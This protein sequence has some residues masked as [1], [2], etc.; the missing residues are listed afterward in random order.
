MRL[1]TGGYTKELPNTITR[2]ASSSLYF[3][4]FLKQLLIATALLGSQCKNT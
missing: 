3:N 4:R 1:T 2:H